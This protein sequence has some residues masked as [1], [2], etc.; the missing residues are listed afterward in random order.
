MYAFPPVQ[1]VTGDNMN[2]V[3]VV[4]AITGVIIVAW[5]YARARKEYDPIDIKY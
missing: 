5:W 3:S 4:Y 1:P 2:Y